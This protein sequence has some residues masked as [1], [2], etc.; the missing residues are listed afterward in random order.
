MAATE[1]EPSETMLEDIKDYLG[2]TW[3]DDK[4]DKRITGY[5]KRGMKRLQNIAG[6]SLDFMIED[7]PRSLLFDYCRYANSQALEVFET[8]FEADLNDLYLRTQAVIIDDLT[9]LLT[10]SDNGVSAKITPE[11]DDENSYVYKSGTNLTVPERMDLCIPGDGWTAWS[12]ENISATAGSEIMIVEIN[13][14]FQAE[15][16]GKAVVP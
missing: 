11:A 9:V 1:T 12:G 6:A 16:A 10:V 7:L 2:I 5:I 4:T 15:R 13:S 14:E 8:N 3:Q